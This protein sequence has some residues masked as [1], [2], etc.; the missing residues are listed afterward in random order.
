GRSPASR[1]G[2]GSRR[3][4]HHARHRRPC[5]A[6]GQLHRHRH[7]LRGSRLR[8]ARGELHAWRDPDCP[9]P[10]QLH[11]GQHEPDRAV[12][13]GGH[14]HRVESPRAGGGHGASPG[15]SPDEQYALQPDRRR[16][17][18]RRR[19]DALSPPSPV[20]TPLTACP[21]ALPPPPT[22]SLF[23][24]TALFRSGFGL[25]VVNFTRGGILLAQARATA[26]TGSTTLTVP[27]PTAATAIAPN[28]P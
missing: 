26:M 8:P 17:A 7:G 4:H 15:A 13:D 12:P 14:G 28:L 3:R 27:F 5:R 11:D 1:H 18:H 6:A 2:H 9:G 21:I 20:F 10:R 23:P 24:Y 19:P 16:A 22:S 25:P